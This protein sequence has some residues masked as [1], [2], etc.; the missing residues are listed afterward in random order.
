MGNNRQFNFDLYVDELLTEALSLTQMQD[1]IKQVGLDPTK[2]D[3]KHLLFLVGL[4][5]SNQG[6]E[7]YDQLI[8]KIQDRG[9]LNS[10]ISVS[11]N[12]RRSDKPTIDLE[13]VG[14][15]L[16]H[17]DDTNE[18][19]AIIAGQRRA[20]PAGKEEPEYNA[21]ELKQFLSLYR[22]SNLFDILVKIKPELNLMLKQFLSEYNSEE[23]EVQEFLKTNAQRAKSVEDLIAILHEGHTKNINPYNSTTSLTL[24]DLKQGAAYTNEEEH[25]YIIRTTFQDDFNKSIRWNL[26]YGQGNRFGLCISCRTNN[27]YLDYRTGKMGPAPLTTYFVYKLYDKKLDPNDVNNYQIAIVDAMM[28]RPNESMFRPKYSINKVATVQKSMRPHGDQLKWVFQNDDEPNLTFE[29]VLNELSYIFDDIRSVV[30]KDGNTHDFVFDFEKIFSSTPLGPKERNVKELLRIFSAEEFLKFAPSDQ[31]AMLSN[32]EIMFGIT[33]ELFV[34]LSPQ[35]R[36]HYVTLANDE[37]V[38]EKGTYEVFSESEKKIF[39]KSIIKQL[40]DRIANLKQKYNYDSNNFDRIINYDPISR[41][42]YEIAITDPELS[43]IYVDAIEEN[44]KNIRDLILS[45]VDENG[46]YDRDLYLRGDLFWDLAR[47][48]DKPI[49]QPRY[50]L[51]DLSDVIVEGRFDISYSLCKSL[52]GCPRIIT[53]DFECVGN[54]IQTLEGGPLYAKNYNVSY[55]KLISLKGAPKFV[56]NFDVRNNKLTNLEYCPIGGGNM[57]FSLNR[58]VSLKGSPKVVGGNFSVQGNQLE[59]LKG[60][61]EVINGSYIIA[62]NSLKSLEGF[63]FSTKELIEKNTYNAYAQLFTDMGLDKESIVEKTGLTA[64]AKSLIE[65]TKEMVYSGMQQ[66]VARSIDAFKAMREVKQESVVYNLMKSYLLR[67]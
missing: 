62:D 39:N 49:F 47:R 9:L 17:S 24:E 29:E 8:N 18:L 10:L 1:Q 5:N 51:P 56:F 13:K 14:K 46:V 3:Q 35:V 60:G 66:E 37:A 15:A 7:I 6:I 65:R 20:I 36:N 16:E 52:K 25:L 45:R 30:G 31:I 19:R 27:Y 34:K 53:S 57:Y 50:V 4:I 2:Y 32:D 21:Y 61:P 43:K 28:R 44:N 59:S 40:N 22:G 38:E 23:P 41:L 58:L 33:K 64:E 11:V 26:K 63:T 55:N 67:S 12:D 48:A 42:K 54:E